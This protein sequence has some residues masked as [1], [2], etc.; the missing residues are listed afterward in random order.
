MEL[1][2]RLRK[3]LDEAEQFAR[4]SGGT[5]GWAVGECVDSDDGKTT[6]WQIVEGN[7]PVARVRGNMRANHIAHHD[8]ASV[9]RMVAAHRKILDLHPDDGQDQPLCNGCG[10]EFRWPC[11]TLTALAEAYG[12]ED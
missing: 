11:P 1:T 12:I 9:L 4:Y 7:Y 8:P 3:A 6:E 5:G 10:G 2:E